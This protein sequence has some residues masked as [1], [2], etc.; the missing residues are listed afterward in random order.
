MA[1]NVATTGASYAQATAS[2][3]VNALPI[4]LACWFKCPAGGGSQSHSLFSLSGTA[5]YYC[6][7][8]DIGVQLG[9]FQASAYSDDGTVAISGVASYTANTWQHAVGVFT[10]TT[11]RTAYLNGSAATTNTTNRTYTGSSL[12]GFGIHY[13]PTSLF[14]GAESNYAVAEC[15]AWNVAL[16]AD[17]IAALAD[18]FSPQLIRPS[19]LV[20]YYPLIRHT[21]TNG[22]T[23]PDKRGGQNLT[24]TGTGLSIVEHPRIIYPKRALRKTAAG[25]AQTYNES[26]DETATAAETQSAALGAVGAQGETATAAETQSGVAVFPNAQTESA[27]AD[28][29]Q[30]SALGGVGAQ[31]ESAPA[32]EAQSSQADLVG[33]Q[34]EAVT[35]ADTQAGTFEAGA[36]L[37]EAASAADAL[38]G[39]LALDGDVSE[40]ATA[41]S[42]E[43][44]ALEIDGQAAEA[45]TASEDQTAQADLVGSQA[46][47]ATGAEA[48]SAQAELVGAASEAATAADTQD[49]ELVGGGDRSLDEAASASDTQAGALTAAGSAAEAVS[50]SDTQ[51]GA[52]TAAGSAAEAAS[53]ADAPSG[54]ATIA[55]SLGEA[56]TAAET[57][58]G[59]L[60]APSVGE[61]GDADTS[62]GGT[63]VGGASVAEA[64]SA[65]DALSSSLITAAS[66][67]AAI[68]AR[69]H[70][71]FPPRFECVAPIVLSKVNRDF[72][73]SL[74]R[75]AIFPGV[76]V[77]Q[78]RCALKQ[79]SL[80]DDID[81]AISI[82]PGGLIYEA[83]RYGARTSYGDS[84]SDTIEAVIGADATASAYE[85]ASAITL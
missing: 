11:S 22:S 3:P 16:T 25:G 28:E 69:V 57:Q 35:A 76:T 36:S 31:S 47:T 79:N 72:E 65:T 37:D 13:G 43:S 27:S 42:A 75:S 82:D 14:G 60:G 53:A 6:P 40:A 71:Q 61:E 70:V 38:T 21:V 30:E 81:N 9:G 68:K 83:W 63:I 4:T 48:Q 55:A 50:A 74:N 49:S 39:G 41:T 17:E 62:Q 46:E 56:A 58:S 12:N 15:A 5:G 54:A 29:S 1:L 32:S 77:M 10:S 23:V 64:A 19:A 26:R 20:A 85:L 66:A 34:S 52:L 33:A 51:A 45:A 2:P 59:E 8:F 44:A 78:L 24:V 18:G 7:G 67:A 84:L 73:F 80:F